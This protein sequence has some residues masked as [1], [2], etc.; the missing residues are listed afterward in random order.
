MK[1]ILETKN[2]IHD[3]DGNWFSQVAG[4]CEADDNV[5]VFQTAFGPFM[6]PRSEVLAAL[7]V[8]D[9]VN[10]A[11]ALEGKVMVWRVN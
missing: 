11:E 6:I 4:E 7:I 10:L 5:V 2:G 3:M 9:E 8:N 1:V